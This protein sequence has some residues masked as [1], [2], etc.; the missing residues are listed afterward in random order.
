MITFTLGGIEITETENFNDRIAMIHKSLK[1]INLVSPV[2]CD[3]VSFPLNILYDVNYKIGPVLKLH[4]LNKPRSLKKYNPTENS[5]PN[6]ISKK[7]VKQT[8]W[9]RSSNH[10]TQ[11]SQFHNMVMLH[12]FFY[13]CYV[14]TA[15]ATL[16]CERCQPSPQ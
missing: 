15:Q 3:E 12:H 5:S 11:H 1:P 7:H 8:D 4:R 2:G 10:W 6:C 13:F 14:Q 16:Q 9:E